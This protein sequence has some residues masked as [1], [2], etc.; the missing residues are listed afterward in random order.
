MAL[1]LTGDTRDTMVLTMAGGV[2]GAVSVVYQILQ[3]DDGIPCIFALDR[4]DIRG[5]DLWVLYK[6]ICD[7]DINELVKVARRLDRS[8]KPVKDAIMIYKTAGVRI[9]VSDIMQSD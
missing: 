2:I 9:C 6:N 8:T 1:L 3:R 7:L 5:S 4:H